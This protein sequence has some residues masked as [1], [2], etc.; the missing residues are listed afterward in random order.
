M[1]SLLPQNRPLW[2]SRQ[3][4]ISA[5]RLRSNSPVFQAIRSRPGFERFLLSV[6]EA[7]LLE[8]ASHGPIVIVNVSSYRCDALIIEQACVRLLELPHLS[9]EAIN[10]YVRHLQSLETLGWLW[11]NIVRPVLDDLGFTGPPSGS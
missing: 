9:Q 10:D 2:L 5:K 1:L 4:A 6:S 11:D 7:D 8:A 3:K